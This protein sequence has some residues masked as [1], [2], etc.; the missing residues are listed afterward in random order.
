[1][2]VKGITEEEFAALIED[3]EDEPKSGGIQGTL[4]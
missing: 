4:F 3:K 2:G 1:M